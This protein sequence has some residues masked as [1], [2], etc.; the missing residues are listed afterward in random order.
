MQPPRELYP[1]E[2]HSLLKRLVRWRRRAMG[3]QETDDSGILGINLLV[4]DGQRRDN[5]GWRDLARGPLHRDLLHGC[6][7]ETQT[8]TWMPA[9]SL[10]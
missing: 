5:I 10:Q 4:M 2:P 7:Q 3:S 9:N 1:L 6:L 8:P